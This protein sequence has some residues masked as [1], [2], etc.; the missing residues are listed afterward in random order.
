MKK[1]LIFFIAL[2]IVFGVAILLF[3]DIRSVNENANTSIKNNDFI[4][5]NQANVN[6]EAV[7]SN[8]T[9]VP[10][11]DEF[12]QRITKKPFGIYITPA[13]SPVQPEK[14]SG[15]HTGVDVEFT[16]IEDKVIVK[17]V[18]AG[19]VIEVRQVSGY[20]GVVVI[21]HQIDD[22]PVLGLY[23]HLNL[24]SVTVQLG[25]SVTKGQQIG[26]LGQ[27]GPETDGERKHLHFG[28]I[29]GSTINYLGYVK[30]EAELSAWLDPLEFY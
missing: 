13:T 21:Q 29:K 27:S 3:W 25:E 28:L 18:A 26:I 22:Q 19:Q 24:E 10:P 4:F 2:V 11:V 6:K 8:E 30:T 1:A 15:Y 14:F 16:D 17:S 12:L 23:G 5:N 9:L 7:V 20:G